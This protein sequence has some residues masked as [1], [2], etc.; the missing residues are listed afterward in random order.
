[1]TRPTSQAPRALQSFAGAGGLP[2]R[3][4][5]A[6][7]TATLTVLTDMCLGDGSSHPDADI[8]IARDQAT[9]RPIIPATSQSGALRAALRQIDAVT[10]DDIELL[11]GTS[12]S[13]ALL[14]PHDAITDTDPITGTRDG[15]A[16]DLPTALVMRGHLFTT[17]V[18]SPGTT[19]ALTWEVHLP[20][21]P[22]R[23]AHVLGL[24]ATAADTL[25]AGGIRL[26]RRCH[27]GFGAV[28][29]TGWG[30]RFFDMCGSV[31]ATRSWYS[32]TT[33]Q[34]RDL[35]AATPAASS[36]AAAL[37]AATPAD[38]P[39][40]TARDPALTRALTVQVTLA[41]EEHLAGAWVP[42]PLLIGAGST[43]LDNTTSH[44]R[45]PSYASD[46]QLD[47]LAIDSGSTMISLLRRTGA[48]A[49]SWI[50]ADPDQRARAEQLLRDLF[51]SHPSAGTISAARLSVD[52]GPFEETRDVTMVSVALNALAHSTIMGAL[53]SQTPIWGGRRTLTIDVSDP[54]DTDVALLRLVLADLIDGL[55]P[56][57]GAGTAT[58]FGRRRATAVRATYHPGDG[59]PRT[60][61]SWHDFAEDSFVAQCHERLLELVGAT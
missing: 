23:A 45:R 9:G 10:D 26:G 49:M 8:A 38:F 43:G 42:V 53:T 4:N 48:R 34:R 51:G 20:P 22:D 19:F 39:A 35:A 57:C 17:E 11:F 50:A 6:L 33:P 44:L 7:L 5:I 18:L 47:E 41:N 40:V 46:G 14:R 59:Q 60:W 21:E 56:S 31:E 61:N 28:S 1:M 2:A 12:G 36:A 27:I 24:A 13:V 15:I 52:E 58:G 32:S 30:A 25:C 54:G 3:R 55:A 16:V 29:A 37:N